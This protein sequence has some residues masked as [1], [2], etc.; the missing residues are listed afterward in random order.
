MKTV[1]ITLLLLA[2]TI[3]AQTVYVRSSAPQS[4][5]VIGVTNG[6]PPTVITGTPTNF[7]TG[8]IIFVTGVCTGA[9]FV[10]ASG[11]S[12][13]NGIRKVAST[14]TST[15]FTITDLS[16]TN[17]VGN[18]PYVSCQAFPGGTSSAQ[19]TGKLTTY[20]LGAGPLG[21]LDGPNGTLTRK[22]ALG[23]ASGLTSLVVSSNV[24]TAATS[25][26]NGLT[27]GDKISVT[28]SGNTNLD[29]A[30]G[31]STVGAYAPYPVTVVDTT[32]FTFP[33]SGVSNGTYSGVNN[34]CGP[35]A[36]P[37]DTIGGTQDCLRIS[38]LAYT[39]NPMWDQLVADSNALIGDGSD[40]FMYKFLVDGGVLSPT[41]TSY[42]FGFRFGLLAYRFLVDQA[43]A[44]LLNGLVY[45]LNNVEKFGGISFICNTD[46]SGC[47]EDNFNDFADQTF[48]G[49]ASM[50]MVGAPYLSSAHELVFINKMYNDTDDPAVTPSSFASQDFGQQKQNKSAATGMAQG[51]TSSSLTLALSDS[52]ANNA[53]V[54]N[55]INLN[56]TAS[57]ASVTPGN[58]TIIATSTPHGMP[59]AAA[60]FISGVAGTGLSCGSI[61]ARWSPFDTPAVVVIDTTHFS[62]PID[63]TGCTSP[64]GGTST[65]LP[66]NCS[67]F[68][69]PLGSTGNIPCPG[70]IT[71]YNSTTKVATIAGTWGFT[72]TSAMT[73]KV[74]ETTTRPTG[75][76]QSGTTSS[77]TLGAADVQPDYGYV[78]ALAYLPLNI[79]NS[80]F[81]DFGVI[82]AYN[83][84]TKVATVAGWNISTPG[85]SGSNCDAYSILKSGVTGTSQA[86]T[87]SSVTLSAGDTN[88]DGYY[89]GSVIAASVNSNT[90][91][92]VVT[93]YNSSTK[94]ALVPNGWQNQ[95]SLASF[96]PG[97]STAVVTSGPYNLTN[98]QTV[99][100]NNVGGTGVCIG[101]GTVTVTDSTHFTVAF[102]SS[103]CVSPIG[104]YLS[105]SISAP[106][107][108]T[109]YTIYNNIITGYNTHF[110]TDLTAKDAVF[111]G[112]S[113]DYFNGYPDIA[114]S[115]VA[116]VTDDTHFVSLN[117]LL[118]T[119]T[120]SNPLITWFVHKWQTGDTG[121][122]H[123]QKHWVGYYGA[124]PVLYPLRGGDGASLSWGP[125]P[126]SNNDVA[127]AVSHIQLAVT[128]ASDSR[129]LKELAVQSSNGFDYE[130]AHYMDYYVGPGHSGGAYSPAVQGNIGIL[131]GTFQATFPTFPSMATTGPWI[132]NIPIFKVYSILPDLAWQTGLTAGTVPTPMPY[133]SETGENQ[134]RDASTLN[135]L[136]MVIDPSFLFAPTSD[137]AQYL[138]WTI[139]NQ[140][141]LNYWGI[142][143][144]TNYQSGVLLLHNDPRIGMK[145]PNA[146]PL[147]Y[148]FLNGS[149]PTCL[150]I[151]G[152]PC[153]RSFSGNAIIS[154]TDWT[155]RSS[156]LFWFGNRTYADDHDINQNGVT[157]YY[158][159][160]G[161]LGIDSAAFGEIVGAGGGG[162]PFDGTEKQ[163]M[164]QFAGTGQNMKNGPANID[165]G[166]VEWG[167]SPN[168]R[169]AS[170]NHG[171]F[172]MQYGDQSSRYVYGC[173]DLS[174]AYTYP[175]DRA[176]RC[177]AHLKNT[178]IN[179]G[180]GEEIL[181][182]SDSVSVST[183]PT[184]V[185][186]HIHYMQNGQPG[187]RL[188]PG[189][190]GYS[191]GPTTCT[192]GC[193]SLNSGREIVSL[194]DGSGP[195][196]N[197]Q[198]NFGVISHYLSPGTITVR[199]DS[200]PITVSSVTK[201]PLSAISSI[202]PG[203]PT[204]VVTSSAVT[205]T[206]LESVIITGITG[207][208]TCNGSG[209]ILTI[210]DSTHFTVG[211]NSSSCSGPSGGTVTGQTVFNATGHGLYSLVS[212]SSIS[213]AANAVITFSSPLTI[214]TGQLVQI[215]GV[216]STSGSCDAINAFWGTP[217]AFHATFIDSTHISIDYTSNLGC[218]APTG[219]TL[220]TFPLNYTIYQATGDW[221]AF[222]S[223]YSPD[224]GLVATVPIDA[225]HFSSPI[226]SSAFS[227]S[228]SGLVQTVYKG[229]Y[230]NSHRVSLCAGSTCGGSVSSFNTFVV[231]KIARNLTD[232]T[233]TTTAI[234]PDSN[235]FG[236]QTLDKVVLFTNDGGL[237]SSIT[238]FTT[239]HS[240]TAQYLFGG[241]SPGVY[242]VTVGGTAVT[243]SP[244]TVSSANDGSIYFESTAG[245][246]HVSGTP[247]ALSITTSS[248]PGGT[249]G[250]AYSQTLAS[251]GSSG[252]VTWSTVTGTQCLG[253][254]LNSTTGVIS[255]TP[256]NNQT[257]NV[258]YS[259]TDS[260]ST[261]NKDLSIL[262]TTG[263]AL[264]VTPSSLTFACTFGGS[265]PGSQ[266]ISISANAVTLDQWSAS[267]T[268]S[269][270][271]LS[272]SSG[273]APAVVAVS[274]V[275]C[276]SLSPGM[277]TD[278][279]TVTSTTSGITN[280]PQ[281]VNIV[282]NVSGSAPNQS[283]I[284]GSSKT[285]GKT[286]VK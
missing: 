179:G 277:H 122:I 90:S 16:G 42:A 261:V 190:G 105:A 114:S 143:A 279:I 164:I 281:M 132:T 21:W 286:V 231:H 234:T 259:A 171:S 252:S 228:F 236:A 274:T 35:A 272:S 219:G 230:G 157:W 218:T 82:S 232:T 169:W 19:W 255:G 3:T 189:L 174:E 43:N 54:N 111:S 168:I 160:G 18:G 28:G 87:G 173:S 73:Y 50:N 39:G 30:V 191:E 69:P 278:T 38:Q 241:F 17:I 99:H 81:F 276:G 125:G 134:I 78:G 127:M 213:I 215:A 1:I 117:N 22:L 253:L 139:Q 283:G 162:S 145:N 26:V 175:M 280:S 115:F 146:Q 155:S 142:P 271:S 59:Q 29:T 40:A 71:A 172:D 33:T 77:V 102:D 180:T 159:V 233:L 83:A 198:R 103:S 7:T 240:G 131:A 270:L 151:T 20:T 177:I 156:G 212:I 207:T 200:P 170:A 137:A 100:I 53:Y 32:H 229:G 10:P 195:D 267:K 120:I 245:T 107:T 237:H 112:N 89:V 86:G 222:N 104:G 206:V 220:V 135:T 258:R 92:G 12:P 56:F 239:T 70:V 76:V 9:V 13:I 262:I 153:Q 34:A 181:I 225:N 238:D 183:N 187:Y 284:F 136:Y 68:I 65:T 108:G 141:S 48:E 138:R 202:T 263:P 249:T 8:D 106:T 257:C 246:V 184:S 61:N 49:L 221:A 11:A 266:N 37:N 196:N 251:T 91:F 256:Y 149:D 36:T 95:I 133:A 204:A 243:G 203:N 98:G 6:T 223:P 62:I 186:T 216:S 97:V 235:W 254:T 192:G 110:T 176:V 41:T 161:L 88:P 129:A 84:S 197:P 250:S 248:L 101:T 57:I 224:S 193:S 46:G 269:W 60:T 214:A 167:N 182:Q 2:R 201:T 205:L 147:Q 116:A 121:L 166:I 285:L 273:T 15:S 265:D 4:V 148:G 44:P 67:Y 64:T 208:G 85:C 163:D 55:I 165:N 119:S 123:H 150:S 227:G 264:V 109:T 52:A 74:L 27:T 58:P 93:E 126:G 5:H 152:W 96:T 188:L 23:T 211:Y 226:N 260:V 25:Y 63:T 194:E 144:A 118:G 140:T 210:T 47:L 209:V 66:I 244:F 51:G 14:P 282:L 45:G 72:P 199:D 242:A 80:G 247:A 124:Q 24:A 275:G 128:C 154:K 158:R 185:T 178:T 268:Q 79:T 31:Q 217:S 130:L 94:V 75:F 113:W